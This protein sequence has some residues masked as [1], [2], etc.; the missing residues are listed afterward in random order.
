MYTVFINEWETETEWETEMPYLPKK[1]DKI[2]AWIRD[3]WYIC[4][5]ISIIHEFEEN[6]NFA[7]TE[8]NIKKPNQ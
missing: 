1:G 4:D 3:K 8:I 5:I 2:G 7:I 6:G